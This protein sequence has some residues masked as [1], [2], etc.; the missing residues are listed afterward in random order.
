MHP[1]GPGD[2]CT[3]ECRTLLSVGANDVANAFATSVG[4]G[5]LT[6]KNAVMLAAVFEFTGAMFMGGHVVKTI[7]KGIANQKCFDGSFSTDPANPAQSTIGDPG[8]LMYGCLCVI[9]AVSIWLVV[10]SALE[11]PVSTTHSCVGGMIGMTLVARGSDCVIWTKKSDDFPY[12]KGVVAVIISWLLSPI[13]SGGFAFCFFVAL[14]TFVMRSEHSYTR[15][16]IAFPVLLG[17]TLCINI[18]FIVYKGAKFLELDNTPVWKA[19]AIGFGVGGGA[20]ILSYFLVVPYIK[21]TTDELYDKMQL[22]KAETGSERKVEETVVRH[23]RECPTG[24][25]GAPIRLYYA[26]QDHLDASLAHKASDILEEDMAVNAIHENAEK[27]DEKTELCMRYLQILTACC[28][29]FAHGANDVANSIGPFAAIIVIL[30]SGKVGKKADMGTDAY[31]ILGLGA[32][33]IVAGLALYGYKILHALGTKIAKLTPSRGI[34]IELGAACVI[35][36]GSRM[37]WPLSTTHCQVGATVGVAMLEG[38][39]GIN[40]FIVGKTVLGWI[41]TLVVVGMSTSIFFAQGAFAPMV[42]YPCYVTN[43][44]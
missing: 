22:E 35:I 15:T 36:M 28:D 9:F 12:V 8:L 11:M 2:K 43:S 44:C 3:D 16:A 24:V 21:R 17:C 13:I 19:C 33:G 1:I 14:R 6:I 20:G 25:F 41:I 26:I 30:K 40:W 18:F 42:S 4:S 32:A 37:G 34:C 38:R 27:F 10:A 5:A 31:W 39:K 29:S 7:R 23:P